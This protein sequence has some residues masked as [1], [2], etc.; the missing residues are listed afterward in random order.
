MVLPSFVAKVLDKVWRKR[1]VTHMTTSNVIEVQFR[2]ETE[3]DRMTGDA[4]DRFRT[5]R[6]QDEFRR[7]YNT[8]MEKLER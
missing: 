5:D 2:D 8:A 7:R 4:G 6:A 1:Y 3:A